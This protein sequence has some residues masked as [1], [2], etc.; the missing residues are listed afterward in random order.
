M[1]KII[2]FTLLLN[3]YSL[4]DT[5][6]D[7]YNS[8]KNALDPQLT[9]LCATDVPGYFGYKFY[10]RGEGEGYINAMLVTGE[11]ITYLFLEGDKNPFNCKS[12]L[13][14]TTETPEAILKKLFIP[15]LKNCEPGFK[16]KVGL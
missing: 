16:E 12:V 5:C 3:M 9:E 14:Q 4:A 7:L 10:L 1:K 15:R 2:L 8:F 13:I 6:L 11:D